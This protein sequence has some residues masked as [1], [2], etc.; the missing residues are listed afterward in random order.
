MTEKGLQSTQELVNHFQD[1]ILDFFYS[2]PYKR[3]IDPISPLGKEGQKEIRLIDN[4]PKRKNGNHWIKHFD[5][6][7]QKQWQDFSYK[8]QDVESL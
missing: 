8:I 1:I 4:F 7:A 6:D 2:S 5:D 3:S